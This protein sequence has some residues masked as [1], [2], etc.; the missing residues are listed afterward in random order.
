MHGSDLRL[1]FVGV[2]QPG[3]DP[4]ARGGD[5]K[6]PRGAIGPAAEVVERSTSCPACGSLEVTAFHEVDRVPVHSCVLVSTRDEALDFPT[7]RIRLVFCATC[8]FIFNADFDASLLDYSRDYEE[9]QGFS[10][11]FRAFA[12]DLAG[13]LIDR[14]DLHGKEILEIGC[15]K[16][17][18]ILLLGEMG[19]NRG[20]GIDPAYVPERTNSEAA[21]RI[22]FIQDFYSKAY[23]G[24]A[25]DFICCRHTLE[26]IPDVGEFVRLV[27]GAIGERGTPVFFEVPD[28]RRVVREAA[29][30]DIYHEHC[31]YFTLGSLARLFRSN[32]FEVSD[33]AL[34]FDD[35]YLL[36]EARPSSNGNDERLEEESVSEL[37]AEVEL[38]RGSYHETVAGW[39]ERLD[40]WRGQGRS[41]VV[42]GSGSKGV[43]FLT[44]LGA[45]DEIACVVDV[46]PFRQGKFMIGTGHAIV[47]PESL[48][49]S[50]PDVVIVMNSIYLDEIRDQLGSMGLRPELTSV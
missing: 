4:L 9:T 31:S 8:G 5:V 16:G 43:A 15:G 18:F 22:T 45:S 39:A 19:P 21:G 12:Q 30:W 33:L 23:R 40:R 14:F 27:R 25:A 26:H 28:T 46:N 35:Q 34:D 49:D 24:L 44:T 11:R 36:L 32:G 47:A 41:V 1:P 29:F 13:R 20:I 7:G 2:G 50:A 38:F 48:A 37:A 6:L 42:W 10:S 17:E 3:A